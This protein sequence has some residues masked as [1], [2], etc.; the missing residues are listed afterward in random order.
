MKGRGR[1][2]SPVKRKGGD[3]KNRKEGEKRVKEL[4]D[5]EWLPKTTRGA[6]GVPAKYQTMWRKLPEKQRLALIE[7]NHGY[8][9]WEVILDTFLE[10][11]QAGVG[12]VGSVESEER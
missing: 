2:G 8:K 3:S 6:A 12:P 1:V 11:Q 9:D 5:D 4:E 7:F 10:V